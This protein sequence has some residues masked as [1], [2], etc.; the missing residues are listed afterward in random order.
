SDCR[1]RATRRRQRCSAVASQYS[2]AIAERHSDIEA[3]TFVPAANQPLL[4]ARFSVSSENGE[5]GV[6]PA[7]R[8]CERHGLRRPI[9]RNGRYVGSLSRAP[10]WSGV[11]E[12]AAGSRCE[13]FTAPYRQKR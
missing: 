12:S 3:T 6:N 9:A 2:S 11:R 8:K 5:N 1:T 13:T 4:R 10:A 7:N